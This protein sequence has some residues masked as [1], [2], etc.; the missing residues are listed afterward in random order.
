MSVRV[1]T[2]LALGATAAL[3]S[4]STAPAQES[5]SPQAAQQL[6]SALAGRTQG[7]PI[8]CIPNYR[9]SQMQVIDDWTILFRDGRTIYVQNPR[10][11]C[12]GIARGSTILVSRL[13]GGTQLCS[14]DIQQLVDSSTRMPQ[15]SCVFGPFVPYTRS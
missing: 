1:S 13:H 2:I 6:A 4:C 11:G 15:G 7:R 12:R 3:A 9:T 10:G 14:G 8:N 5:R